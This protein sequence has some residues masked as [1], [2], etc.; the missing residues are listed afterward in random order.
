MKKSL[1][2]GLILAVSLMSFVSAYYGSFYGGS[3]LGD[4]FNSMDSTTVFL[5]VVFVVSFA[6]INYSLSIFF[7]ENKSTASV[8][9]LAMALGITYWMNQTGFDFS[10]L[11]YS[12]GIPEETLLTLAPLLFIGAIVAIGILKGWGVSMLA[13]GAFLILISLF[14]DEGT[15]TLLMAVGVILAII[16]IIFWAKGRKEN[17]R[18]ERR[19]YS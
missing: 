14:V 16:G 2:I 17:E 7:K 1:I 18:K 5:G 6:L 3:V 9:S 19:H 10:N 12:L 4:L 13:T 15:K 11:F 8:I